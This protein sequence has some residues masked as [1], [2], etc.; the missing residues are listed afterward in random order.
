MVLLAVGRHFAGELPETKLEFRIVRRDGST[1]WVQT[2]SST[3][4]D[5]AGRPTDIIFTMRDI[6]DKKELEAQLET[7]A[8]TDALTGLANRRALDEALD[9]EWRRARREGTALSLVMLDTDHFK[10]FNDANGHQAGDD[11]LRTIARSI[12]QAVRRAGELAARYGGEEFAL[13]LPSTGPEQAAALAEQLRREIEALGIPHPQ[14]PTSDRVTVS[15]GV[16]T[17]L[18]ADGA[19]LKMPDGLLEAADRALYKAK[20]SG[21]NRVKRGPAAHAGDEAQ[22]SVLAA[23]QPRTRAMWRSTFLTSTSIGTFPPST[24]ASLNALRS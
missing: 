7:L 10:A 2:N 18:A 19:S 24:T 3:I 22:E 20:A 21:R 12:G 17:A 16:A 6:S 4:T 14:S 23:R 5:A 13:V 1:I 15:V 8:R 11:C 9:L